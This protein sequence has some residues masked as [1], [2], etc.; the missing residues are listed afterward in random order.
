[1]FMKLLCVTAM[2]ATT[3]TATA[4]KI[5]FEHQPAPQVFEGSK[6]KVLAWCGG[7]NVPQLALADLNNDGKKDLVVYETGYNNVRTF[8]NKGTAGNPLYRYEPG[9]A[10]NFPSVQVFIK[11]VDY[12]RDGISDFITRGFYGFNVFKGYFD[13][14]NKLAFN[15]YRSMAYQVPV[16]PTTPTGWL[17]VTC[18][19][20]DMPDILDIDGDGD[21]DAVSFN[22]LGA[23]I[24][25]YRNC[26]VEDG[27]VK[28]SIRVCLKDECWGRT[29]Q[30]VPRTHV[31]GHVC[32]NSG[33][34]CKGCE[35]EDQ[36][37]VTHIGGNVLTLFDYDGDGDKDYMTSNVSYPDVQFFKN[38]KVEYQYPIDTMIAQ[39]TIWDG[40]GKEVSISTWA[41]P[42]ALD[43]DQ[44]G[45]TDLIFTSHAAATENYKSVWLFKNDGSYNYNYVS[46]SFLVEDMI[47]VGTGSYPLFY[48]FNKD[49]KKD[50]LLG[51][52][53]VFHPAWGTN[54]ASISYFENTGTA[55]QPQFTLKTR[56]LMGLAAANYKGTAIAIGD[57]DNDGKDDLVV[58]HTDGTLSYFKNIAASNSVEPVWSLSQSTMKDKNGNIIDVLGYAAPCI[59]DMNKDGK[60]DLVIG[61]KYGAVAY[62]ENNS[63]GAGNYAL[64]MVSQ[65]LGD[66][67]GGPSNSDGYSTPFIGRIDNTGTDYLMLGTVDGEI[68]RF[69]GF[70]AGN[71]SGSYQRVDSAYEG[72]HV[73]R[74]S[75][76]AFA[77]LDGDGKYEMVLGTETGG[78]HFFDQYFNV[79]IA[80]IAKG[81][82]ADIRVYPNPAANKVN[83]SW[84]REGSNVVTIKIVSLTGQV[85]LQHDASAGSINASLD[86]S[87]LPAGMYYCIVSG[88]NNQAVKPLAVIR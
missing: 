46:D 47:D 51:S 78:L 45:D 81:D 12:D 86:I 64:A 53:G 63:T 76:P 21:L 49:G 75:A 66:M 69:D 26:Q 37:R 19:P 88:G 65:M 10:A 33:V 39:D 60:P 23:V 57:L 34:S 38:G 54:R 85:L 67:K 84:Q 74:R 7:I 50:L 24:N 16:A 15:Y 56:D 79:G 73:G 35:E 11:L 58:G 71:T 17:P 68:N 52:D 77:D 14:Q 28:D 55:T 1:M 62:Y 61:S 44:D 3:L 9:Y 72:I 59:Y 18:L 22:Q 29:Y 6:E 32:D 42:I 41:A 13:A 30:D 87:A 4:Q 31:L 25:F 8:I 83:V 27:L 40:N 43:I 2:V 20:E 80:D 70:Q 82:L 36:G 5:Y 48:D